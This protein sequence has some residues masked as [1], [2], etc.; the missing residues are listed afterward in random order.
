VIEEISAACAGFA[1]MLSV[2]NSL[3]CEI[4]YQFGSDELKNKYLPAMASGEKIGAYCVTEPN[5]G[6]DSPRFRR[7]RSR[8]GTV[9]C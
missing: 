2:H 6:T 1:I 4:I 3:A 7:W 8:R 5:A 9:S